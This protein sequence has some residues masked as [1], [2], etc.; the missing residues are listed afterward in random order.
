MA[1][2]FHKK[3][4]PN[5][6]LIQYGYRQPRTMKKGT[7]PMSVKKYLDEGVRLSDVSGAVIRGL[8][9]VGLSDAPTRAAAAFV[10]AILLLCAVVPRPAKPMPATD[11]TEAQGCALGR[12]TGERLGF[13]TINQCT[14]Q[15]QHAGGRLRGKLEWVYDVKR[16]PSGAYSVRFF[17]DDGTAWLKQIGT[18][19]FD[20]IPD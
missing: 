11:L 19:Q 10:V 14:F 16:L 1:T 4:Y 15:P 6:P 2:A 9:A 12:A 8:N 20:R 5:Q 7:R 17:N 18:F 13:S 3:A